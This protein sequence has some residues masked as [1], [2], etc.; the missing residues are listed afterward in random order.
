V[1][2]RLWAPALLYSPF[3]V[4]ASA[5][6][7]VMGFFWLRNSYGLDGPGAASFIASVAFAAMIFAPNLVLRAARLRGPQLPKTGEEL[8]YDIEPH[9]AQEVQRRS[10]EAHNFLSAVVVCACL[11]LPVLFWNVLAPDG[12]V[13]S[14]F[15]LMLSSALLLRTRVFM[16]LSQ[17]VALTVA[18]I[19]GYTMLIAESARGADPGRLNMLVAL[20]MVALA[21]AVL[22]AIRP[23]PRRLLPIWEFIARILDV[24]TA[25]AVLPLALYLMGVY[26]WARGLGG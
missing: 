25:L 1:F 14:T 26:A 21:V 22:A 9:L 19:A 16:G 23:W 24:V 13:S 17:R 12:W 5:A 18:G 6:V 4:L 10:D 2:Q 7:V 8:R 11:V 15:V 20:L 3:L